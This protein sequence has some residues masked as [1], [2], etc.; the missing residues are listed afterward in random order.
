MILVL[1]DEMSELETILEI[2]IKEQVLGLSDLVKVSQPGLEFAFSFS[3]K[4]YIL[5]RTLLLQN[6]CFDFWR[7]E[8]ESRAKFFNF[9]T[10]GTVISE[11]PFFCSLHG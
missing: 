4:K 10:P 9:Y 3:V 1:C 7:R 11:I 8:M 6:A 5:G 2:V